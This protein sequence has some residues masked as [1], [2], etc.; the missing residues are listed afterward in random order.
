M[1]EFIPININNILLNF[2]AIDQYGN[3]MNKKSNKILKPKKDKDGYLSI[4]LCTNEVD[5]G[6]IHKRKTFRI[7]QLV[8]K[9][10]IGE[11][12]DY[13]NDPTIDHIDGDKTNNH[14]TNL[15]WLERGVNSAIRKNKGAGSQNH[16]AKLTEHQVRE[17][18]DLL[19]N[20]NLSFEEIASLYDV[21]KTTI[22]NI[23]CHKTWIDITS[24]YD[25]QY[26]VV[27][28]GTDGRFQAIHTNLKS[29]A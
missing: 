22:S 2:Y 10:Y 8:A 7:A 14:F 6:E 19:I 17:I 4:S 26:R 23:K 16:E 24:K 20:T 9:I 29:T 25:F 1:N 3:I 12:P 18:C 11:P 28:R 21:H 5:N 15:R 27:I 13:M